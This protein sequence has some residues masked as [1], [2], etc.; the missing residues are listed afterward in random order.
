MATP[1]PNRR[2]LILR[3]LIGRGAPRVSSS[4][5]GGGGGGEGGGGGGGEARGSVRWGV[6]STA[7]LHAGS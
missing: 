4:G 3:W 6:G 2:A 5:G 7:P 1:P